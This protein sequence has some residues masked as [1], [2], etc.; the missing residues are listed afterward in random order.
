MLRKMTLENLAFFTLQGIAVWIQLSVRD[1]ARWSKEYPQGL[2]RAICV[3]CHLI[4]L[5]VTGR[6][7]LAPY[8]R[9]PGSTPKELYDSY[10][11]HA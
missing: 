11:F 3:L 6:L 9:Y 8:L 2:T 10:A 5:S 1:W 7:F 4:F